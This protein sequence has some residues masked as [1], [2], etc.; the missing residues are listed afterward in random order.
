ML[1]LNIL[2]LQII[3]NFA[4]ATL[5]INHRINNI[6]KYP[7]M[8]HTMSIQKLVLLFCLLTVKMSAFSYETTDD[9]YTN[10]RIRLGKIHLSG[11]ISN[12]ARGTFGGPRMITLTITH[13]ITGEIS[14][15]EVK[16]DKQGNYSIEMETETNPTIASLSTQINRDQTFYIALPQ[17]KEL[18][19][20]L[21]YI[22]VDDVKLTSSFKSELTENDMLMGAS[23]FYK[24]LSSSVFKERRRLYDQP[25]EVFLQYAK[26][27]IN[28]KTEIM[29]KD[30]L[31]SDKLKSYLAN[32]ICLFYH[33]Y[34][35]FDYKDEMRLNYDNIHQT[36]LLQDTLNIATP[37]RSYYRFMKNLNLNSSTHLCS[38]L[39]PDLQEKI[40][41]NETL[42]IPSIKDTPI[43]EWQKVVK[44]RIADLI[45]FKKGSYYDVLT[46]NAYA[47]QLTMETTPLSPKQK[48]NIHAYFKDGEIEKILLRQNEKTE[49]RV[50]T[51]EPLKIQQADG[52]DANQLITDI[53]EKN[54]GKIVFIDFWA[55][56]C[57]PC[58]MALK[59]MKSLELPIQKE[60]IVH[61]YFTNGSSP[62][63]L[64]N[65][66]I[67]EIGGQQY[68]L[69]A[70]VWEQL[71]DKY[72]FNSIPSYLIFNQ[73]GELKCQFTGY[74]GNTKMA[75][76][77]KTRF[78]SKDASGSN[79]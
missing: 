35:V 71:M 74:P 58:L 27:V 28:G 75:E 13:P 46:A 29:N 59:E 19:L 26:N 57:G 78:L 37:S 15:K 52:L 9:S 22:K 63:N 12:E 41:L 8:K 38:F 18:K 24:V 79:H 51:I 14:K 25:A 20:D 56:W 48:E 61:I 54:K 32:D 6:I 64:W 72:S 10:P 73:K 23:I 77:I 67:Q 30:T 55:T 17:D 40:L 3:I 36:P 66:K 4:I 70:K 31:I 49:A 76:M 5:Q 68:Y 7:K 33:L 39:F 60:E 11:K 42:N 44:E 43:P 53:L 62:K 2:V 47:L 69:S 34:H 16:T 50:K 1:Y 65:R 45:G 21:H